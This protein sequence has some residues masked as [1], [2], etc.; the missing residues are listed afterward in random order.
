MRKVLQMSNSFFC[1]ECG[2]E[3]VKWNGKCPACGAWDS[4]RDSD[5]I[6]G[7]KSKNLA[8][9]QNEP[10]TLDKIEIK[11]QPAIKTNI[12]EFDGVLGEGIIPGM[13]ALIGGE[14]GIGKSTLMLQIAQQLAL[15]NLTV[16]Y[17]TGEE[18]NEQIK[19]RS[20]R[21]KISSPN[22]HILA[23]ND[24]NQIYDIAQK[25]VPDLLIVDSIQ[26]VYN[27]NLEST[28]GSVTQLRENTMILTKL[29]KQK[30]IPVLLIGHVTK[31][32]AVAG[33]KIIEHIVD[34]VLYFEGELQNQLKILRTTK[35]RFGSTNNIGI[36][37]M[38]F[39]GL[40]EVLNPSELFI[41]R[42]ETSSGV[43]ISCIMEG[44]RPFLVEVQALITPT[45]YG[46]SQKVCNGI[47]PKKV[48]LLLA[49]IE[50]SLKL[51][52]K[53]N[54]VFINL[55]GGIKVNDPCL[56]LAIIAA[57]ISSFTEQALPAHTALIGEVGLNGEVRPI[58]QIEKRIKEA[59]RLGYKK[60]IISQK[61]KDIKFGSSIIGI[62]N[63][64]QL[65][66]YL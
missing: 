30:S 13:V 4:F 1:K 56:D 9:A 33:P 41:N 35:N 49:V 3:S 19:L 37:E 8:L 57:M 22:I 15:Q 29:A 2:F 45:N 12:R 59:Q 23:T 40:K 28:P 24:V 50:K 14:P 42:D 18:S 48:S 36:F 63:I 44:N 47:D 51:N 21:L 26:S 6:I 10:L 62:K 32:G 58:S 43:A 5:K 16:L 34:T 54:D 53:L 31:D 52:L 64:Q 61:T 7:K 60:I 20:I 66:E 11:A 55:I 17:A 38:V 46:T 27:S 65:N 39:D 25:M